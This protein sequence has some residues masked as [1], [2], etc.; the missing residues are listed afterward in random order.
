VLLENAVPVMNVSTSAN[1]INRFILIG[2]F[3]FF[4]FCCLKRVISNQTHH[5][6]KG[7][8][9]GNFFCKL[10]FV[11]YLGHAYLSFGDPEVTTGN[12]ISDFVKGKKKYDYPHRILA[13]INLH[14]EIDLFTDQHPANKELAKIFKPAYGL[15]SSAFVDIVYDHFIALEI[16]TNGDEHLANFVQR[17]YADVEKFSHLLPPTFNTLFP[18]MK[19]QNW[20]YNYQFG[21]GIEKSLAGMVHRA[22]Y[23]SDSDTAYQLYNEHYKK[24]GSS[25]SDFF[26]DLVAFSLKKFSD[27]H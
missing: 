14:R 21:W 16:A 20:L 10:I 24:I 6:N 11:N 23:I 27:I 7:Y 2:V 22:K 3:Y 13:G 25:F 17:V 4:N 8:S 9:P 1:I 5:Q 18:F 19:Q 12:I 26:P 15:Y